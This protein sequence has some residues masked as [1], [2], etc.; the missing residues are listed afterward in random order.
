MADEAVTTTTETTQ[1]ND[2]AGAAVSAETALG[3][4]GAATEAAQ[5]SQDTTALGGA[6]EETETKADG[7]AATEEKADAPVVPEKYELTVSEGFALDDAVLAEATPVFQELGLTNEQANKLMPVAEKFAQGIADA[8]NRQII[9]Q[10]QRDRAAWLS[11]AK[12][13]PEIGGAQWDANLAVAAKGLD[14]LGYTKGTQ[15][16]SLLNDSGLGNHPD[17]IRAFFRVGKAISEDGFERGNS[18]P[19]TKQSPA[20]RL[21]GSNKE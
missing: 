4:A 15:F 1:P 9:E 21:Y 11:D 12:A 2:T 10:V 8:A 14:A 5:T 20:D 3:E 7:E 19:T 17:M 18:T 6:G 16:R 13:D